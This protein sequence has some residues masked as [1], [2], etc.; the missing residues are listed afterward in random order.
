MPRRAEKKAQGVAGAVDGPCLLT[1]CAHPGASGRPPKA[2]FRDDQSSPLV[3]E[4]CTAVEGE[5][6]LC[7]VRDT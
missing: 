7:G 5:P 3:R 1:D 2:E 4:G 6:A